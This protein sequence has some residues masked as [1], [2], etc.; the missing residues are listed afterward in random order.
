MG[1]DV[2]SI[3]AFGTEDESAG[4][5]IQELL[6]SENKEGDPIHYYITGDLEEEGIKDLTKEQ[7]EIVNDFLGFELWE[8]M[9]DGSF[10]GFGVEASPN[11]FSDEDKKP[12]V[13][14]FNKYG[15]GEP[16]WVSFSH[17]W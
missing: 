10:E 8:N 7:Q 9:Y 14:L 11:N 15:L 16:E 4:K 6:S 5:K 12:I 1:V 3:L 13:E 17:W 2:S